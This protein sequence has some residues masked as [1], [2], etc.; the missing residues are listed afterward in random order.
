M[1]GY[2]LFI[3]QGVDAFRLFTGRDVDYT[4]M[5]N[6]LHGRMADLNTISGARLI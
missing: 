6:A 4:T 1:S 5:R 3:G 2:E